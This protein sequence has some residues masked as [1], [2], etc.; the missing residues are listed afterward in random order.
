MR[1]VEE[2]RISRLSKLTFRHCTKIATMIS[3][4]VVLPFSESAMVVYLIID[5]TDSNALRSSYFALSS[6]DPRRNVEGPRV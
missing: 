3:K 6:T 5:C 2:R 1:S 4:P